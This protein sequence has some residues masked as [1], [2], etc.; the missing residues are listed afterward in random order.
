MLHTGLRVS[1]VLELTQEQVWNSPRFWI[2][3]KK[4]GKSKMVGLPDAL[5]REILL[6][7]NARWAFPGRDPRKHRTRQAVWWDI[8]RAQRAFRIKRN[9][10]THS[11]R[12]DYAA[13]MM[14]RYR[15]VTKVQRALNHS[16]PTVTTLYLMADEL[17]ERGGK[18]TFRV[19][20]RA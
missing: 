10:G 1:D 13:D 7:S 15:D 6:Q 16:S 18:N 5:R 3:E 4:T 12:K 17:T 19:L 14:R 9:L 8:K 20:P 11:M 2:K